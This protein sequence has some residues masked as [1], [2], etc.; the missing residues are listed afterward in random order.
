MDNRV[1]D[2]DLVK[3]AEGGDPAAFELL[4]ERYYEIAVSAA[5][6]LLADVD[7]S[8]DCAQEA[9][10]EAAKTLSHI[11]DKAKFGQWIYGISRRKA[12]YILRRQKLHTQALR[13]KTDESR[14]LKPVSSPSEQ[15]SRQ[16]KHASVLRALHQVSEKYREVL[17]LKCIDERSHEDIAR[18]LNISLAAVDK[19][20]VRGKEMLREVLR[21]WKLD[22]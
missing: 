2:A 18:I 9:F 5:Y 13:V 21:R 20:L 16:E 12:I 15:M 1:T 19:R 10:L 22:E 4:V 7:S 6:S 11:R 3:R 17:V 14:R 8:K